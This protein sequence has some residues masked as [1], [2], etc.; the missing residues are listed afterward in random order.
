[1]RESDSR[2][3]SIDIQPEIIVAYPGWVLEDGDTGMRASG[4][5][6]NEAR[7]KLLEYVEEYDS[8]EE[9]LAV[10]GSA[11]EQFAHQFEQAMNALSSIMEGSY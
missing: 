8:Y 7:R 9:W 1:M 10:H 3:R 6:Y 5:T 2:L 4:E 11:S